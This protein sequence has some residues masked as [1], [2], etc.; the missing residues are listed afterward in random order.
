[1]TYDV[2]VNDI[3]LAVKIGLF[4]EERSKIQTLICDLKIKVKPVA[5]GFDDINNTVNYYAL[6]EMIMQKA[7]NT[8]FLLLEALADY[9]LN[10]ILAFGPIVNCQITLKKPYIMQVLG[11]GGCGVIMERSQ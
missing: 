11:A 4:P 10:E 1:M 6:T 3:Q 7:S 2:F 8:N 5:H 9:L